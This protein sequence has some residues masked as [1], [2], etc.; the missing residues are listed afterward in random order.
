[1]ITD[2]T[3][4]DVIEAKRLYS[5]KVQKFIPLTDEEMQTL[6]RG[7]IGLSTINRIEAKQAELRDILKEMGYYIGGENKQWERGEFFKRQDLQR[8]VMNTKQAFPV[9]YNE[10][11]FPFFQYRYIN[12]LEEFCAVVEAKIEEIKALYTVCG[13]VECGEVV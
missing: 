4:A 1:M 6:E 5:E 10:A 8:L 13:T 3:E 7:F 2:R 12:R 9:E 11:I